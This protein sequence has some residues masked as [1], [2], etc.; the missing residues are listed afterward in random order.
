MYYKTHTKY[1]LFNIFTYKHTTYVSFKKAAFLAAKDAVTP[2]K[3]TAIG[4]LANLLGG[5]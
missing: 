3:A 4:A 5:F 2:L 1:C